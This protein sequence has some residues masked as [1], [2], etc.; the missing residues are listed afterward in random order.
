MRLFLRA[1]LFPIVLVAV[2]AT[3]AQEPMPRAAFVAK[4]IA[5]VN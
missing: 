4:T 5:I 2:V 3:M 1:F